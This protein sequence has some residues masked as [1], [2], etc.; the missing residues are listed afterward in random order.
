MLDSETYQDL[1]PE[2]ID[3]V[4]ASDL[5]DEVFADAVASRVMFMARVP[6][7]ET[8]RRLMP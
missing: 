2:A 4:L 1:I 7:D 5:P 6:P 3:A 8:G